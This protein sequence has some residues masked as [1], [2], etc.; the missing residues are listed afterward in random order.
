MRRS[1]PCPRFIC[2]LVLLALL[3]PRTLPARAEEPGYESLRELMSESPRVRRA[4]A[5]ELQRAGA[6]GLVP[7]LVDALFFTPRRHRTEL[8]RTLRALTGHDAGDDYFDWVEWLGGR[9]DFPPGD[10]Y[11]AW[12]RELFTRIDPAYRNVFYPGM[13]ARIRLE[14]VVFGGA[15]LGGIPAL[16]DPPHIAAESSALDDDEL[17]FGVVLGGAARAYPHRYL[18]WHELANDIVGGEPIT[19]SFC[20]L[21][22]SGV[23]H[24]AR[25]PAGGRYLFGTSG[26]LYRSNKLMYDRGSLT[27][28]NNL[29]GEPAAGRLAAS[30]IRLELLPVTV[31]T[32]AGWKREHPETT[33]VQLDPAFGAR[34]GYDYR[35]GA[36]DRRRAG[37]AFPV[38][39]RSEKLPAKTEILGLRLGSEA[40][41]YPV[42][43]ALAAGLVHDELA[44]T[45][46]LVVADPA[47]GALR[48]Y[49][50][51]AHRFALSAAGELL[52]EQGRAWRRTE[53]ALLPPEGSGEPPLAR[54]PSHL[55]FWFGWYGF[56][57]DT[58]LWSPE[59]DGS[60]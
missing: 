37:V 47:S 59:A 22:G 28:W 27:L 49:E 40:K 25:T 10:G 16:D 52:D 12:K 19:L 58:G 3:A 45:P 29:T 46:L 20:T 8:L 1:T 24:H 36:A 38:W 51:R 6:R 9:D 26:L 18:S 42:D 53:E 11:A 57:P 55:A 44:D 2:A 17:V 33:V 56:Y 41:A 34:W 60:G 50:R 23:V 30:P 48:A 21:C 4:A 13:P 5:L 43:A 35:P 7:G 14:E 32:W 54:L 31:T 15:R 39:Q